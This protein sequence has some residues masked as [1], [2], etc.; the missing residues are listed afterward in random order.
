MAWALEQKAITDAPARHVLLCLAN[1][2][3]NLG[4][5]AFPAVATLAG[6]TGL[7]ERTIR[8]KLDALETSGLIYRGNQAMAAAYISRSDRRPVCYDLDLKR[9]AGGSPRTRERGAAD[10]VNGV[11]LTTERGAGAAPNPSVN[12]QKENR[13]EASSSGSRLS[14]DWYL[15]KE[16]FDWAVKERPELD[17]NAQ[18]EMFRDYWHAQAGAKGRKADWQATWRN[19]IRNARAPYTSNGHRA[20]VNNGAQPAILGDFHD[21]PDFQS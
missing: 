9:G 4:R 13:V 2:A 18:G 14:A 21:H 19:W 5:G 11:Q 6:D 7:S 3:D 16:W 1:Y 15:P 10:A 20:P 17:I 12:H 8:S